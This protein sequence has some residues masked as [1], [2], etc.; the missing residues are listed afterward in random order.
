MGK[1]PEQVTHI[2]NLDIVKYFHMFI[3]KQQI[4]A[5]FLVP[6]KQFN[7]MLEGIWG[8]GHINIFLV[9]M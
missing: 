4:K 5:V 6:V 2:R 1:G 3:E 9:G 8:K 7:P